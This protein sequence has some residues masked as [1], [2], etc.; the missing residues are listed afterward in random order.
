MGYSCGTKQLEQYQDET[1]LC[2]GQR[3]AGPLEQVAIG[4]HRNIAPTVMGL[5]IGVLPCLRSAKQHTAA[6][7]S[8]S[9]TGTGRNWY[10]SPNRKLVLS[11]L[12]FARLTK[13]SNGRY[14]G[15]YRPGRRR[16][17]R[18]GCW[19]LETRA[20]AVWV[21]GDVVGDTHKARL[22]KAG[23]WRLK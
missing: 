3:E 9:A 15:R 2:S 18:S 21:D 22:G 23:S 11:Q 13:L 19:R 20:V 1:G 10:P 14:F 17:G 16:C 6:A 7:A 12:E 5:G 4:L 8:A